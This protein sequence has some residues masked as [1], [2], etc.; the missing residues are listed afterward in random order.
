MPADSFCV[1][2]I[3]VS[4][5]QEAERLASAVVTERLAACV[6]IVGGVRSVFRW[7]GQVEVDDECLLVVKTS[8]ERLERL[9]SRVCELHSYDVPEFIALD[10]S[11]ASAPYARFLREALDSDR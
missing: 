1:V 6:N 2:L 7:E 10:L 8:R 9:E 4:N 5:A 11:H 3:T